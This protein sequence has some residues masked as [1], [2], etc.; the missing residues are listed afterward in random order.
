MSHGRCQNAHARAADPG[1]AVSC[2]GND[3]PA[4]NTNNALKPQ[5]AA[6]RCCCPGCARKC[7]KLVCLEGWHAGR[8]TLL[9]KRC[10]A[11]LIIVRGRG[12]GAEKLAP[13][14]GAAMMTKE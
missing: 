11:G 5:A 14:G 3:S 13:A 2:S 1:V 12:R 8:A 6:E 4:E 10:A 9:C 7:T